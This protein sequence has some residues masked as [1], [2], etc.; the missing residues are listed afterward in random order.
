MLTMTDVHTRF[1]AATVLDPFARQA[2]RSLIPRR[3]GET[4]APA[5]AAPAAPAPVATPSAPAAAAPAPDLGALQTIIDGAKAEG[6]TAATGEVLKALG[7]D[8]LEDAQAFVT[9]K[10]QADD[11]TK[12]ADQLARETAEREAAGARAEAAQARA[13]ARA[14]RIEAALTGAGAPAGSVADLS[15]LI[16]VAA[17]ADGAAIAAAAE[18]L[19]AK[20]P[21][22]FDPAA[23]P[24]A[25]SSVPGKPPTPAASKT[26]YEA[27][28]ERGKADREAATPK[29]FLEGMSVL[30][31]RAT[32]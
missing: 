6:Q 2:A 31:Q 29:P 21:A 3:E 4:H 28:R 7:F 23:A 19:K 11:A 25:P 15:K 27:G 14:A 20:Y 12:S 13:E 30:G 17:D 32:N 10:R 22:M 8:K 9:A 1:G 16:D 26:G 24:P 18:A 5:P